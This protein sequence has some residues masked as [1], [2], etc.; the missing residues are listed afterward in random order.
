M[1]CVMSVRPS[2][3]TSASTFAAVSC[4]GSGSSP[5]LSR[6][7]SAELERWSQS[8]CCCGSCWSSGVTP[9]DSAGGGTGLAMPAPG[10]RIGN[11]SSTVVTAFAE[12]GFRIGNSSSSRVLCMGIGAEMVPRID[13]LRPGLARP[14]VF[15]RLGILFDLA[16]RQQAAGDGEKSLEGEGRGNVVKRKGQERNGQPFQSIWQKQQTRRG[17]IRPESRSVEWRALLG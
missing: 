16:Y 9:S 4:G 14:A 17:R 12:P 1:S 3:T 7:S 5:P 15:Q 10:C 6:L 11:S 13:L 8:C 2:S